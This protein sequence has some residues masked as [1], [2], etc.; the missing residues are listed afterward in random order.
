MIDV[1]VSGWQV[2]DRI[3]PFVAEQGAELIVEGIDTKE[4]LNA[5]STRKI[6]YIFGK[7]YK[8][9]IRMK[10]VIEKYQKQA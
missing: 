7:Y 5:A 6:P 10:R 1:S 8:K 9:A 3:L 4:D 2:I